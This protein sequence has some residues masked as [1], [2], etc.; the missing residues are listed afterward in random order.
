M[1]LAVFLLG[2]K[3]LP[4]QVHT[5]GCEL[6]TSPPF[7]CKRP[8]LHLFNLLHATNTTNM[9][10]IHLFIT[11][12]SEGKNLYLICLGLNPQI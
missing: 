3:L 11:K 6:V 4:Q 1:S 5:C 12:I 2:W 8:G 9:G 10:Y 7:H